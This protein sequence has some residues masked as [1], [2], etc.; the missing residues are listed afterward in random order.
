MS[1]QQHQPPPIRCEGCDE[2]IEGVVYFQRTE[3]GHVPTCAG[4][5]HELARQLWRRLAAEDRREGRRPD[6]ALQLQVEALPDTMQCVVCGREVAWR[7]APPSRIVLC[8][9]ECQRDRENAPR[10]VRHGPRVCANPECGKTFTPTRSN[11]RTCS[12]RC[13]QR[14]HRMRVTTTRGELPKP[15]H[16]VTGG[17]A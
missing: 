5:A 12:D 6:R 14:V 11:A 8:S 1:M 17:D 16:T 9:S 2:V 7:G 10:R 3:H 13:R 15:P 4:C